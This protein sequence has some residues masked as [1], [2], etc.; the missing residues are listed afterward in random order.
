MRGPMLALCVV[1]LGRTANGRIEWKD[2]SGKTLRD[3]QTAA[4]S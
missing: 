4:V 1:M 2:A 3:I